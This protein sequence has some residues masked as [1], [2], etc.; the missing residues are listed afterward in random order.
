MKLHLPF[1]TTITIMLL[2]SSCI[3]PM[4]EEDSRKINVVVVRDTVFVE[5][6]PNYKES[7]LKYANTVG[8]DVLLRIQP[9]FN[10]GIIT[11]LDSG[12]QINVTDSISIRY[13]DDW[14]LTKEAATLFSESDSLLLGKY[15]PVKILNSS[16]TGNA[17]RIETKVSGYTAIG[18]IAAKDVEKLP[19]QNWYR[20]KTSNQ[21]G[22]IYGELLKFQSN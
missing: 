17:L 18:W 8:S 5:P 13:C 22:W 4:N 21:K 10:S 2:I 11:Q 16:Q 6:I 9:D 19:H 15:R 12:F 14:G 1:V 7:V 3:R 20:V